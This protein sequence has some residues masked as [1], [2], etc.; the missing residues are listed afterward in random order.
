M[1]FDCSAITVIGLKITLDDLK[2]TKKKAIKYVNCKCKQN[3][4]VQLFNFCPDCGNKNRHGTYDQYKRDF[5]NE[6]H[7]DAG[8]DINFKH[9]IIKIGDDRYDVIK[10]TENEDLIYISLYFGM[11]DGPTN[12]KPNGITRCQFSFEELIK[13]KHKMKND[14]TQIQ[15]QYET[16]TPFAVGKNYC[17]LASYSLWSDDNFGIYTI[18]DFTKKNINP[19]F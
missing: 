15:S 17:D 2:V 11:R 6:F 10:P 18:I 7:L 14:L 19:I 4:E 16:Y 5:I 8:L 1:E 3:I 12:Y 9:G 13:M